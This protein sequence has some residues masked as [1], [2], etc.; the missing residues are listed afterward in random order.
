VICAR[1]HKLI[2]SE[3][4]YLQVKRRLSLPEEG[5]GMDPIVDVHLDCPAD[6]PPIPADFLDM[7]GCS[8]GHAASQHQYAIEGDAIVQLSAHTFCSQCTCHGFNTTC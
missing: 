4:L 8:C 3:H 2:E 7:I 6:M 1:C 5:R